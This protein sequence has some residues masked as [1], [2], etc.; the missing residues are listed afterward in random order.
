LTAPSSQLVSPDPAAPTI[1]ETLS[2]ANGVTVPTK[3]VNR[4]VIIGFDLLEISL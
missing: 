3:N 1:R 2:L 4:S